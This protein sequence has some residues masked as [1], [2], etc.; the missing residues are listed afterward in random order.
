MEGKV[1]HDSLTVWFVVILIDVRRDD[2]SNLIAHIIE[3]CRY[4]ASSNAVG[5]TGDHAD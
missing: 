5:I 4:G 2:G 1:L 3:R